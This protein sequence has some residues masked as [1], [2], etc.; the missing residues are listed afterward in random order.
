MAERQTYKFNQTIQAVPISGTADV[1]KSV[2]STI[3][4][5]YD[6]YVA[7]EEA[8]LK[9]QGSQ[10][11][12]IAASGKD[13]K[14]IQMLNAGTVFGQAFNDSAVKAYGAAIKTDV[15]TSI[16][17]I[18]VNNSENRDEYLLIKDKYAE[19]FLSGIS[20]PT[21]KAIAAQKIEDVS[22]IHEREIYA[23]WKEK[24]HLQN[25]VK[26]TNEF[27]SSV[28]FSATVGGEAVDK[29]YKGYATD[30]DLGNPEALK[31]YKDTFAE[32]FKLRFQD[33]DNQL[34]DMLAIPGDHFNEGSIQKHTDEAVLKIYTGVFMAEYDH[35]ADKDEGLAFKTKFLDDPIAYI[36]SQP[37]LN[38]LFTDDILD[39]YGMTTVGT[40]DSPSMKEQIYDS[41]TKSWKIKQDRLDFEEKAEDEALVEE[42][43]DNFLDTL[44]G[45]GD[46]DKS[47]TLD[48]IKENRL[49]Y[50]SKQ[51][52]ILLNAKIS[53]KYEK[54]VPEEV[55]KL[56]FYLAST[57]D[58]VKEQIDTIEQ[59][60]IDGGLSWK[61]ASTKLKT[62]LEGTNI[63]VTKSPKFKSALSILTP[64][65]EKTSSA[66]YGQTATGEHKVWLA[67]ATKE[68]MERTADGEDPGVIVQ[69]IA[70]SWLMEQESQRALGYKDLSPYILPR[71]SNKDPVLLD[72]QN[73]KAFVD[74]RFAKSKNAKIY[75][76]D[77]TLMKRYG[78]GTKAATE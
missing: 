73:A 49:N 62:T 6:Q 22:G 16:N 21:F 4:S 2:S 1:W 78:C 65:F 76:K 8:L 9:A 39:A 61:T 60:V 64:Q 75:A 33:I 17:E 40:K 52:E 32:K 5:F 55:Y 12:A 24:T 69:E 36:K 29:W 59:A 26:T 68:L 44:T 14:D 48:S 31:A 38:E 57:D 18:A 37:H 74:G 50:T 67:K 20:N 53:G 30:N 63:D 51:Y 28:D 46:K 72:C 54:D 10:A 45:M 25:L 70:T 11:G 41:M 42:Q 71:K 47:I 23:K 58:T 34:V 7:G 77:M 56:D 15:S 19:D 3:G 35:Y 43:T 13:K 66:L 27:E